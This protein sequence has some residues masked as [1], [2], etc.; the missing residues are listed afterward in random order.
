M[1]PLE[2]QRHHEMM[3]RQHHQGQLVPH[4]QP[5]YHQQDGAPHQQQNQQPLQH[6]EQQGQ[7]GQLQQQQQSQQQGHQGAHHQMPLHGQQYQQQQ[8]QQGQQQLQHQPQGQQQPHHQ[9]PQQQHQLQQLQHHHQ[10]QQPAHQHGQAQFPPPHFYHAHQAHQNHFQHFAQ[11]PQLPQNHLDEQRRMQEHQRQLFLQQQKEQQVQQ[12]KA[13][14]KAKKSRKRENRKSRLVVVISSIS[15]NSNRC[16]CSS[17]PSRTQWVSTQLS[18][19]YRWFVRW[20]APLESAH[21][22][23]RD[24]SRPLDPLQT[25]ITNISVSQPGEVIVLDDAPMRAP[26]SVQVMGHMPPPHMRPPGSVQAFQQPAPLFYPMTVQPA[27]PSHFMPPTPRPSHQP[28]QPAPMPAPE[29]APVQIASTEEVEGLRRKLDDKNRELLLAQNKISELERTVHDQN[30]RTGTLNME[31]AGLQKENGRLRDGMERANGEVER[32]QRELAD[33]LAETEA[34]R[35][36]LDRMR[37]ERLIAQTVEPS[38]LRQSNTPDSRKDSPTIQPVVESPMEAVREE[39]A[40]KE[41]QEFGFEEGGHYQEPY[42]PDFYQEEATYEVQEYP[43]PVPEALEFEEVPYEGQGS[44]GAQGAQEDQERQGSS[45][46]QWNQM[47][48]QAQDFGA[49]GAQEDQG[50]SFDQ[51]NPEQAQDFQENQEAYWAPAEPAGPQEAQFQNVDWNEARGHYPREAPIE[52]RRAPEARYPREAPIEDWKVQE[53]PIREPVAPEAVPNAQ[54]RPVP[55]QIKLEPVEQGEML[56]EQEAHPEMAQEAQEE[57]PRLERMEGQDDVVEVA[58]LP[59][60][61]PHLE[62]FEQAVKYWEEKF[63]SECFE[64]AYWMAHEEPLKWNINVRRFFFNPDGEEEVPQKVDSC[65]PNSYTF[66]GRVLSKKNGKGQKKRWLSLDPS[67]RAEWKRLW[68]VVGDIQRK[69]NR[70]RLVDICDKDGQVV[71]LC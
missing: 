42:Q 6:H 2:M 20:E 7:Q 39:V 56:E 9:I 32:I 27:F 24:V 58:F 40:L 67:I 33:R 1:D 55:I 29:P 47:A 54:L 69:Q 16:S 34:L 36:E 38:E 68:M 14:E 50:S 48:R 8:G 63:G 57:M 12:K 45:F 15:I 71:P 49:Q 3:I 65:C 60:E 30:E 52:D 31:L 37:A 22:K 59:T 64:E 25:F 44:S 18:D 28:A 35:A 66:Y 61:P 46:A 53:A 41:P 51:W 26:A 13:L 43:S 17:G 21:A 10:G 5:Q 70:L 4:H 23:C 11:H 62:T 19:R